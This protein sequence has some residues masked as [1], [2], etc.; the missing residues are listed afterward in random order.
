[1]TRALKILAGLLMLGFLVLGL[2]ATKQGEIL[3]AGIYFA[4]AFCIAAYI[5]LFGDRK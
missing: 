5:I 2:Y 3:D 1:M 4:T